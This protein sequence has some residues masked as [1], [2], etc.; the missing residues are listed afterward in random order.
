MSK[1]FI[2]MA[3]FL[4]VLPA[5]GQDKQ[6]FNIQVKPIL[7]SELKAQQV[8]VYETSFDNIDKSVTDMKG[9][10]VVVDVWATWCPPCV[11]KFPHLVEIHKSFNEAGVNCVSISLDKGRRGYDINKVAKFLGDNN[12]AFTNYISDPTEYENI[13]KRFGVG[14]F[15]PYM[16]VFGKDGK[17]VWD[18]ASKPLSDKDIAAL[19]EAELKK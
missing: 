6:V 19:I 16:V 7:N 14:D 8:V 10:V 11:R 18:S 12:A 3:I 2:V 9:K 1:F 17:K 13:K 15:I 4:G 5:N